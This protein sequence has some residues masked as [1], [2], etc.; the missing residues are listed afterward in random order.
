MGEPD[1]VALSEMGQLLAAGVR[2]LTLDSS[3]V[4]E[5]C[6]AE[7]RLPATQGLLTL[8][9]PAVLTSSRRVGLSHGDQGFNPADLAIEA[10]MVLAAVE[11]ES[12][13]RWALVDFEG[14]PVRPRCGDRR[15]LHPP[16][17]QAQEDC[18]LAIDLSG[19]LLMY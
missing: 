9:G 12:L 7:R 18:E 13:T 6:A 4:A 14:N 19:R 16:G 2:C 8:N 17:N 5:E 1:R 10:E 15:R 3:E 11:R